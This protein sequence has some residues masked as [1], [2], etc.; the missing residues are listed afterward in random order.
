MLVRIVVT[1]WMPVPAALDSISTVSIHRYYKHCERVIRTYT[2][3][4]AYGTA[5]FAK[6]ID[7]L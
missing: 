4:L 3:G 2:D 7:R 1:H 6:V 5:A